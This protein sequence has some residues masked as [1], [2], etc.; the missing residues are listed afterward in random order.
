[1]YGLTWEWC[2]G[3]D[4]VESVNYISNAFVAT[5]MYNVGSTWEYVRASMTLA[6]L[7]PPFPDPN[8]GHL[9]MDGCYIN[10]VPGMLCLF[11]LDM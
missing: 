8:D 2:I 9:L 1:M 4:M 7:L 3:L 10:N 6:M 11:Q 5:Y